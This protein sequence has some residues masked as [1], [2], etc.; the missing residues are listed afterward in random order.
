[1][2]TPQE[3]YESLNLSKILIAIL[4]QY[5]ELSVPLDAF[6]SIP[7]GD[8]GLEVNYDEEASSFTFKLKE[9]DGTPG[10]SN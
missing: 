8:S 3:V 5:K 7:E 4:E 10:T 2:Q 1:M 6:L 9:Q